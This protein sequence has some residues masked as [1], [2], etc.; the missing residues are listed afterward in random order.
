[1]LRLA[2]AAGLAFVLATS[3]L[4]SAALAQPAGRAAEVPPIQF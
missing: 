4:A 2:R 3:P 1:M